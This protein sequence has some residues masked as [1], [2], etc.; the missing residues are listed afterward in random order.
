MSPAARRELLCD[1]VLGVPALALYLATLAPGLYTLDSAE[2][3]AGAHVVHATG[4]P[5]Y[6]LLLKSWSLLVPLEW[7]GRRRLRPRSAGRAPATR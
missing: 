5:V 2:L 1:L 6:L 4:Y 7:P 3:A